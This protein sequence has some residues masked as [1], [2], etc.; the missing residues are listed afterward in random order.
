MKKYIR[1]EW[2]ESH[3]WIF[4]EFEDDVEFGNEEGVVFVPEELY[5]ESHMVRDPN[6]DQKKQKPRKF[7]LGDK[8]HWH[9]DDTN[10]I[11]IVGFRDDAY[12]TDSAYGLI[13]YC[14]EDYLE[15]V[16]QKPVEW[17]EEE[18]YNRLKEG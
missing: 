10:V 4:G 5:N 9:N 16:E 2:P 7:K 6:S 14:D 15:R 17:N 13:L 12:L 8:V 3:E 11:T 1:V 18:L